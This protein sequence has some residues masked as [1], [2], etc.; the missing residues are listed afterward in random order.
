M[1]VTLTEAAVLDRSKT[2]TPPTWVA[3]LD[4][5]HHVTLCRKVVGRRCADGTVDLLVCLAKVEIVAVWSAQ[6]LGVDQCSTPVWSM[7]LP[8][9]QS[10]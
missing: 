10:G 6:D 7:T 5:W 4:R 2:L 3:H 8:P 1:S 9:R